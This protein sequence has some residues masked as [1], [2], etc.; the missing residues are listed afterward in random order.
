[1]SHAPNS[2]CVREKG[3]EGRRASR[4]LQLPVSLPED[5][6]TAPNDWQG[7]GPK[8][9]HRTRV[10]PCVCTP[11]ACPALG[12]ATHGRRSRSAEQPSSLSLA[13]RGK[14]SRQRGCVLHGTPG[15]EARTLPRKGRPSPCCIKADHLRF[16][17]RSSP[18]PGSVWAFDRGRDGRPLP[19]LKAREGHRG[20]RPPALAYL[21]AAV[22]GT[23]CCPARAGT[24]QRLG[25]RCD[26]PVGWWR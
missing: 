1:M 17:A 5:A 22:R 23:Q 4:N 16:L 8:W 14:S 18:H 9:E 26:G 10:C 19:A 2:P 12:E 3:R 21:V 13:G 6:E 7:H 24:A 15:G 20:Q 25:D 11:M